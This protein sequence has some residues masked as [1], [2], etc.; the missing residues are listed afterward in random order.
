[1][2]SKVLKIFQLILF[3]IIIGIIYNFISPFGLKILSSEKFIRNDSLIIKE[4]NSFEALQLREK[5]EVVFI[6]SRDPW[7]YSKI[8]VA[9]A[10]NIPEFSFESNNS[11]VKSLNKN[12]IYIVYC[13]SEDCDISFRLA[14]NLQRLKF[15]NLRIMK[16]GIEGWRKN[17]FPVEGSDV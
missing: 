11:V 17:Q 6:D 2:K 5:N 13:S 15:I 3:P 1:M 10:I 12:F 9:G 7:E 8:H 16:D 14:R 4:I